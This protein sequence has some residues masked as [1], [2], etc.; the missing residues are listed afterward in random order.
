MFI[1]EDDRRFVSHRIGH[2]HR[3]E[4]FPQLAGEIRMGRRHRVEQPLR[5][6]AGAIREFLDELGEHLLAVR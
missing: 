5:L 3:G 2:R 6:R 4:Q 1:A